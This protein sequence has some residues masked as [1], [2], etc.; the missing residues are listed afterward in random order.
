MQPALIAGK[1]NAALRLSTLPRQARV[2][3]RFL[4]SLVYCFPTARVSVL[5]WPA[6]GGAT[7]SSP[8][9]LSTS[10]SASFHHVRVQ[11]SCVNCVLFSATCPKHAPRLST[12]P[13]GMHLAVSVSSAVCLSSPVLPGTCLAII[14]S[15]HACTHQ[16]TK[17]P[18]RSRS[19]PT[20]ASV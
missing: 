15:A 13:R 20:Y 7:S 5:V 12:C 10:T 2:H 17:K 1:G 18:K 8:A 14:D 19:P 16:A 9:F 11:L 3:C 6:S 4:F